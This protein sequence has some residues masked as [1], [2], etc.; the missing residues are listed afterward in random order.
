MGSISVVLLATQKPVWV[1]SLAEG[2]AFKAV[3][4]WDA[5]CG[6]VSEGSWSWVLKD[7]W[8]E[9]IMLLK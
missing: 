6:I 8:V 2:W 4:V 7:E 5:A 3:T 9:D 1:G